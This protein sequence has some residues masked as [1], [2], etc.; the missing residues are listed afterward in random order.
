MIDDPIALADADFDI[1]FEL[2]E[3]FFRIDLVKIVSRVW[4]HDDHDKE[5]ATV[6]KVTIADGRLEEMT[7][8]F[9]PIAEINWR[10]NRR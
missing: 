8:L 2:I 5:V 3:K 1:A 6:V 10:L 7:V 9:D 4:P